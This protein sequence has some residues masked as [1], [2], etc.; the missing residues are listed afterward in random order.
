MNMSSQINNLQCNTI[1]TDDEECTSSMRN[2]ASTI[3]NPKTCNMNNISQD[4]N[5]STVDAVTDK[6]KKNIIQM[7]GNVFGYDTDDV[8]IRNDVSVVGSVLLEEFPFAESSEND[9][10][11]CKFN[12]KQ[13]NLMTIIG[14]L[15]K[16]SND[17]KINPK[18]VSMERARL[19]ES[20][21]QSQS[22][23]PKSRRISNQGVKH[24]SIDPDQLELFKKCTRPCLSS[25]AK[26]IWERASAA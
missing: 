6:K 2:H 10:I 18:N 3:Q 4:L 8:S 16:K 5:I 14:R 24:V 25:S 12:S 23:Q 26:P 11:F 17:R 7:E 20:P 1:A 15:L 21:D 19:D 22:N 9:S 13:R